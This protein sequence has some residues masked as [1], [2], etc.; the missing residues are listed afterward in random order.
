[1]KLL[2]NSL[3]LLLFLGLV[4]AEKYIFELSTPVKSFLKDIDNKIQVRHV[5][6]SD[7][8]NGFSAEF[9]SSEK[10]QQFK[11]LKA[12][13]I[14]K[15]WPILDHTSITK[16]IKNI[17]KKESPTFFVPQH[18]D[19]LKQLTRANYGYKKLNVNGSGI[20]VGLV[21]S[22]IDYTHPALG[23]CFGKGC[24]VAYGYDLVGNNYN[25]T[26]ASIKPSHDP[27]DNC[28]TNSSKTNNT[29]FFCLFQLTPLF[30]S[31]SHWSWNFSCRFDCSRRQGIC[32]CYEVIMFDWF[33]FFA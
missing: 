25:G 2:Y 22:G 31:F 6:D 4:Y 33:F 19:T 14:L 24:K 13:H 26:T 18:K 11:T 28:P 7:I 5:Y 27:L 21:D 29:V 10:A 3:L 8:L 20:K 17:K 16:N 9:S 23:G 12:S 32:K 30:Y 15:S 1:M